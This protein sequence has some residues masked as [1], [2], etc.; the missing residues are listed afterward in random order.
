MKSDLNLEYHKG[1][2]FTKKN[3]SHVHCVVNDYFPDDDSYLVTY[4][5]SGNIKKVPES[6]LQSLYR[7]SSGGDKQEAIERLCKLMGAK[8]HLDEDGEPARPR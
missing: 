1:Q 3:A 5:C 6:V 2:E 8:G 4:T 7:E